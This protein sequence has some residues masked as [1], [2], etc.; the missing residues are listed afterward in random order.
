MNLPY[1]IFTFLIVCI[2][3]NNNMYGQLTSEKEGFIRSFYSEYFQVCQ[4]SISDIELKKIESKYVNP[5]L[6]RK[7]KKQNLDYNVFINAQDCDTSALETLKVREID[8]NTFE[9]S[10]GTTEIIIITIELIERR[11]RFEFWKIS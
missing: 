3:W 5:R 4:N 6:R 10:Y 11:G 9:V 2:L 1:K 7:I 8:I